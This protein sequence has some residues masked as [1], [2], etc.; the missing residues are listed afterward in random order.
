M[1]I[2]PQLDTRLAALRARL[3]ERVVLPADDA[4]DE[5]RAAWNLAADQWPAAV[6]FAGSVDDVVATVVAARAEGLRVAPQGTGHAAAGL[7]DLDGAVLLKTECRRGVEVDPEQ[8]VVRVAAGTIWQEVV[9]AAAPHGLV[10]LHGSAHDVGVVGYSLG[11]G[12]G[13]LAR[14]HGMAT[15]SIV[16]AE[17]VLADGSHVRA[18]ADTNPELFWALRGGGGNFGVV[19][20]LE[21]RLFPLTEV[22]AGIAFYPLGRAAEVLGVWREWTATVPDEVTSCGRLMQFPPLPEVPEPL[23]G[24]SFAMV[25]VVYAGDEAAGAE[26]VRPFVELGPA[27]VTFAQAPAPTLTALHMDPPHPVPGIGEGLNL[28]ELTPDTVAALLETAG[29]GTNSPFVSVELRQLG[30]ALGRVAPGAGALATLDAA[31]ALYAVGIPFDEEAA[32]A[33]HERLGVLRA[34][35]APWEAERRYANFTEEDV[36]ASCLYAPAALERLAALKAA[37]D[38]EEL[39]QPIHAIRPAGA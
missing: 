19:T 33:I 1:T 20:A 21:L 7:A 14:K 39:F 16:G 15:N 31:F 28:A 22:Y 12:I 29:A 10:A 25:Q 38:P 26:L 24:N 35:L 17:L 4:W 11:G 18:D 8:R 3:G 9:D 32:G 36:D 37:L 34:A 2:A 27:L 23:R 13:W 6:V 5:A 30:G